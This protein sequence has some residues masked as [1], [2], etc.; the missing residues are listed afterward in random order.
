M[1]TYSKK[2]VGPTY[3]DSKDLNVCVTFLR[4]LPVTIDSQPIPYVN[5][6]MLCQELNRSNIY[7]ELIHA[8]PSRFKKQVHFAAK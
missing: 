8:D 3:S 6:L 5:V 7:L 1:T 4:Q 2:N